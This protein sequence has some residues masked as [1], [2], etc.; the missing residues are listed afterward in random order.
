MPRALTLLPSTLVAVYP[1]AQNKPEDKPWFTDPRGGWPLYWGQSRASQA[2]RGE[3][4]VMF[5]EVRFLRN[6]EEDDVQR[7]KR[8]QGRKVGIDAITLLAML[9][10]GVRQ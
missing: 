3:E 10:L 1:A 9:G 2:L 7:R 6:A 5:E 8:Q 4:G